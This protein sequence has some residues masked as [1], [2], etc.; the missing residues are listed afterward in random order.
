[1]MN[2]SELLNEALLRHKYAPCLGY[3]TVKGEYE[4]VTFATVYQRV[5]YFSTGLYSLIR[6]DEQ[7]AMI[8]ICMKNRLEWII[9]DLACLMHAWIDVPF[10]FDSSIS[11]TI[12][13]INHAKLTVLVC[14]QSLERMI[15]LL[16]KSC[17]SLKHVIIVGN[18]SGM[19]SDPAGHIQFH[20]FEQVENIGKDST[21]QIPLR[22]APDLDSVVC[23]SYTS[24]ST[25]K[26][27]G[28]MMS[29]EGFLLGLTRGLFSGNQSEKMLLVSPLSHGANRFISIMFLYNGYSLALYDG[30][31]DNILKE[32][33]IV[34]PTIVSMTP[35]LFNII[36][37]EYKFELEM[38]SHKNPSD[39]DRKALMEKYKYVFG[40][41]LRKILSFGAKL[42]DEVKNFLRDCTGVEVL[43]G[44]GST[45]IA[46]IAINGK[47]AQYLE[48]KLLDVPEMGYLQTDK[49]HPRGELCIKTRGMFKGYYKNPEATAEVV[50][51][52]GYVR[53]GD[54]V[55]LNEKERSI[56]II[57]RKKNML[58][59]SQGKYVA[60]QSIE[61]M[62]NTSPFV[63][64]IFVYGSIEQGYLIA[65]VVP[66]WKHV[67]Q[68]V[69]SMSIENLPNEGRQ[70]YGFLSQ[71]ILLKKRILEDFNQIGK[72][73]ELHK[74]EIPKDLII[75][76][77]RFKTEDGRITSL[78][79]ISRYVCEKYYKDRLE[80][81]YRQNKS[82]QYQ[83]QVL[84]LFGDIFPGIIDADT[85]ISEFGVDSLQAVNISNSIQKR[86]GVEIPVKILF[87]GTI[88][89]RDIAELVNN[90][91]FS[92]N[93]N[94]DWLNEVQ[95]P[96]DLQI[97]K[98]DQPF[99]KLIQLSDKKNILLT[100]ATGFLGV[101]LLKTLLDVTRSSCK[102][103]CLVRANDDRNALNRLKKAFEYHKLE[104]NL[105]YDSRVVA[106]AGSFS[107][108]HFGLSSDRYQWLCE[109]IDV[110]YHNGANVNW[111]LSYRQ[112][113]NENVTGVVRMLQL[114]TSKKLKPLHF[115]SSIG[116]VQ[117]IEG[118]K[119]ENI[120]VEDKEMLYKRLSALNGYGAC[121]WVA[122]NILSI[123]R[124]RGAPITI[125]RPGMIGFSRKGVPNVKDWVGRLLRGCIALQAYPNVKV[126]N[127]D[128]ITVDQ[129]A[130]I[131]VSISQLPEALE[132]DCYHIVNNPGNAI[133]ICHGFELIKQQL[134]INLEPLPFDQWIRKV[135][136][137]ITGEKNDPVWP[138]LALFKNGLPIKEE[139]DLSNKNLINALNQLNIQLEKVDDQ[140]MSKL[141]SEY[142]T[143][144]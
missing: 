108:D 77:D 54:I 135:N 126:D 29:H 121:K 79:K 62:L 127:L 116:A 18:W 137:S 115:I 3:K 82:K 136:E 35:Q 124:E 70:R 28:V 140:L 49:P 109:N 101:F 69:K 43:D 78:G 134:S 92:S 33:K 50:D 25:G 123:A 71:N 84:Q 13:M 132:K 47:L 37:D 46:L 8:G 65:V 102:I 7:E 67:D 27:K 56:K 57:D 52:E 131:I 51:S 14:D 5:Q 58:K 117:G 2:L 30:D 75:D 130:E 142:S 138:M 100:G 21:S 60:P 19:R 129:I 73:N 23:I 139:M 1:M 120:M 91:N 93:E 106:I 4:F 99:E 104:W 10:H 107:E 63:D 40:N 61:A 83:D 74:F 36:Y 113:K 31:M 125:F 111:V 59:L 41:S 15:D 39:S 94:V 118:M 76:V 114:A 119:P 12:Y 80:D 6:E 122:E 144:L 87:N 53:T 26:P 64:Q 55:E 89:L 24:G 17:P 44:Y 48:Y 66:N 133:H 68:F 11:D 9:T 38:S 110:I 86:F 96:Q 45:E 81:L 20:T 143:L 98:S 42:S 72:V 128:E 85:P 16:V 95:L 90:E 103:H 112:L 88:T 105:E 32:Y 22:A 141:F 97:P 34:N